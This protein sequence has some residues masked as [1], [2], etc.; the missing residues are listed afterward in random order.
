MKLRYY[1]DHVGNRLD[2][3][4]ISPYDLSTTAQIGGQSA[5]TLRPGDSIR[6]NSDEWLIAEI[7][8]NYLET[9][10]GGLV[11]H[12]YDLRLYQ[13]KKGQQP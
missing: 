6:L 5:S 12:T 7:E 11:A 13:P 10:T 1:R 2:V 4:G 8:G 9:Q 3:I